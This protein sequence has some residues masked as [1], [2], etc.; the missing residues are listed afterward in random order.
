MRQSGREGRGLCVSE[1]PDGG[2]GERAV[3]SRARRRASG[4]SHRVGEA[5]LSL[6]ALPLRGAESPAGLPAAGWSWKELV[7]WRMSFYF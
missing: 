1:N 3:T 2:G 6:T 4:S 5:G 7:L